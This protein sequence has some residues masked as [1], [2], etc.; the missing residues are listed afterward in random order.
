MRIIKI[1]LFFSLLAFVVSLSA[2]IWVNYGQPFHAE[3]TIKETDRF[4]KIGVV[5]A[6]GSYDQ[7]FLGLKE[8]LAERGYKENDKIKYEVKD[9]KGN[10][11]EVKNAVD[12]LMYD[13][14]DVIYAISTPVTKSVWN[15]VKNK[16][17]I[18]FN[19]VGDP[20]GG[21]FAASYSS[22]GS[23]LT[24]C[25]NMSAELSGKRL[26]IFKEAFPAL[27]KVVTFYN[28]DNA[29]SLLSIANTR[30]ATSG[31]GVY[32]SEVL[33]KD[34][35]E[36]SNA[37]ATI[38]PA[39]YDGIYLTPDAMVISNADMVIQRSLE[40]GIPVM[41]H[42]VSLA[43]KGVTLIYGADFYKLGVQCSEVMEMVLKGQDPKDVPIQIPKE[44]I[45]VINTKNAA[46][47]KLYPT[48]EILRRSDR[49]IQ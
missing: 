22:S 41:G 45:L 21:G 47:I 33:V 14:V 6:G 42:E 15:I 44:F 17:P 26:E 46:Q 7:A 35:K 2:A 25:S 32:L 29:F 5:Y 28:P 48:Q 37:L 18:V 16:I 8:G 30:K 34:A 19:I 24:G 11:N 43:E 13:R 4:H 20:I 38:T 40:L 36:L 9:V 39:Q 31:I 27:K 1:F 12:E 3:I 23:N 49:L 10:L